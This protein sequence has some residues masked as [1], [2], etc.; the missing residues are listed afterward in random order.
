MPQTIV[1]VVGCVICALTLVYVTRASRRAYAEIMARAQVATQLEQ[2]AADVDDG[3]APRTPG[4]GEG[5]PVTKQDLDL[6]VHPRDYGGPRDPYVALRTL[7]RALRAKTAF[8]AAGARR[9]ASMTNAAGAA[10]APAGAPA[11]RTLTRAASDERRSTARSRWRRAGESASEE[12]R[13]AP[14][15]RLTSTDRAQAPRVMDV[16]FRELFEPAL[17]APQSTPSTP[18]A[19]TRRTGSGQLPPGVSGRSPQPRGPALGRTLEHATGPEDEADAL[20]A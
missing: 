10:A 1:T 18:V 17:M 4:G 16:V 3:A 15:G 20:R 13:Q 9:R 11:P 2:A 5:G 12:G 7:K 6:S 8:K 19:R 14:G